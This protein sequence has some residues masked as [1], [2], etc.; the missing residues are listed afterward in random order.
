MRT[1]LLQLVSTLQHALSLSEADRESNQLQLGLQIGMAWN[2]L[3][4]LVSP[5]QWHDEYD[6]ERWRHVKYWD[7]GQEAGY[8]SLLTDIVSDGRQSYGD[9]GGDGR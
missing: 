2:A 8:E 1:A 7:A 4:A 5:W 3:W 6:H 9:P